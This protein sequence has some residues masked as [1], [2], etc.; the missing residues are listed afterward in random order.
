[1]VISFPTSGEPRSVDIRAV[2]NGENRYGRHSRRST[3]FESPIKESFSTIH[4]KRY[5][6]EL[7][8]RA[9]SSTMR[10]FFKHGYSALQQDEPKGSLKNAPRIRTHKVLL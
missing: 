4:Q 5:V 6:F 3:P 7:A 1:M 10:H 2:A 8:Q 9:L